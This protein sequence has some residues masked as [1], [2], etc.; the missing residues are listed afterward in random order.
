[1][2]HQIIHQVR[3]CILKS[4]YATV[5]TFRVTLQRH[6]N[7]FPSV[8]LVETSHLAKNKL[9]LGDLI[10]NPRQNMSLRR[11]TDPDVTQAPSKIHQNKDP[12]LAPT[13][14]KKELCTGPGVLQ[15]N[16]DR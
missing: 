10:L 12:G 1:M 6:C 11:S 15:I 8:T 7:L 2:E 13:A 14:L 16:S 5:P 9:F 4:Q 3:H